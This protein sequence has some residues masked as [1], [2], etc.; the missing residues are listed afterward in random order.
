MI[1]PTLKVMI[2]GDEDAMVGSCNE[3]LQSEVQCSPPARYA[4]SGKASLDRPTRKRTL[5]AVRRCGFLAATQCS[6]CETP[7]RAR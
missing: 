7:E 6:A 2:Q 3:G 1:G 5:L 4:Y